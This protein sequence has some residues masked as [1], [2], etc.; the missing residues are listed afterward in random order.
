ML[1][2]GTFSGLGTGFIEEDAKD[3]DCLRHG[4]VCINVAQ[5]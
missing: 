1:A 2:M 5:Y 4:G 3:L